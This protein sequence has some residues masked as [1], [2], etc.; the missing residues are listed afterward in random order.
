MGAFKKI[1]D[2]MNSPEWESTIKDAVKQ[3]IEKRACK[4]GKND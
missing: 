1:T 4:K 3:E 2:T